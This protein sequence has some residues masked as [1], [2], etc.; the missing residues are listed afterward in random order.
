MSELNVPSSIAALIALVCTA[1]PLFARPG[2][3]PETRYVDINATC[4]GGDG[5]QSAPFCSLVQAVAASASGDTIRIAPGTYRGPLTIDRDLVLVGGEGVTLDGNAAETVTVVAGV[6]ATLEDL[7]ITGAIR[8]GALNRGGLTL[9]RCAVRGNSHYTL[10]N[11]SDSPGIGIDNDF[12]TGPLRLEGCTVEDNIEI[13]SLSVPAVGGLRSR[14]SQEVVIRDSEFSRNTGG[15]ATTILSDSPMRIEG[16]T[17]DMNTSGFVGIWLR[18][19]SQLRS[20]TFSSGV[21]WV[22]VAPGASSVSEVEGCTF[23]ARLWRLDGNAI[24][25]VRIANTVLGGLAES[26][27]ARGDFVSLGHNVVTSADVATGFGPD[28]LVGSAAVPLT[29]GLGPLAD[30]GG[31][32]RT[33]ELLPGSPAIGAGDPVA[34][35]I[36]DQRGRLRIAGAA[37]VGA[38]Q[39]A[40]PAIGFHTRSCPGVLNGSGQVART[41]A[42]GSPI[43]SDNSFTI[44]ALGVTPNQFGIFLVSR[45][46]GFAPLAGGSLCLTGTI[47]RYVGPGEIQDSGPDGR[48]SIS[49][50][51][52]RIPQGGTLAPA[53]PGETWAFQA[54]FRDTV[55]EANLA[56]AT[57]VTFQ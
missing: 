25:E 18:R 47:G 56:V 26:R 57:E 39:T 10:F 22:I 46:S 4:I 49:A 7:T 34:F 52:T 53:Q 14:G 23:T 51:L 42:I 28:D 9:R 27:S 20:S 24:G 2:P 21:P 45:T 13:P 33:M 40:S 37:D 38:Y 29:A 11:L 8:S 30:N 36:V 43:V 48:L 35:E 32:T 16:S 12:P 44:A 15:A 19:P 5:S 41:V 50:D 3:A 6:T 17:F 55:G 31:P 1:A 54:W